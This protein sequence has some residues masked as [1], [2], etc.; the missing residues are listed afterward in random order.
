VRSPVCGL[1]LVAESSLS[2]TD[3]WGCR[4]RASWLAVVDALAHRLAARA[5]G[6]F[7]GD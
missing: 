6:G 1:C 7:F 4:R 5:P 3:L 2:V